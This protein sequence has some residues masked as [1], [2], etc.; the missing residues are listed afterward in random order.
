MKKFLL[1]AMMALLIGGFTSNA[2]A[3]NKDPK[4]KINNEAVN[5][6]T[7]AKDVTAVTKTDINSMIK[8]FELVVTKTVKMF[9]AQ[10]DKNSK[11]DTKDFDK[12]LSKALDYKAKLGKVQK[13]MNRT[14]KRR[15]DKACAELNQIL[16]KG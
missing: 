8:E 2:N 1:F 7:V 15:Y 11:V 3:Q 14:H 9:K 10:S 16:T 6:K 13:E 5:K 12:C 4:A